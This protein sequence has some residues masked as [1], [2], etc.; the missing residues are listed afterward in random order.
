MFLAELEKISWTNA[1]DILSNPITNIQFGS[2]YL[3][4]LVDLF[5]IE[6]GLAAYNGGE[7]KAT[8]WLAN[9][10]AEGIL[11][12]ETQHYVPAVMRLYNL[13]KNE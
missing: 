12:R 7:R 8:L 10:K 6:G 9:N 2:R 5:G 13:Y 4:S 3:S 11:W 1:R